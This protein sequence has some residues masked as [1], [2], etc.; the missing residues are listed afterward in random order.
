MPKW[1]G[2]RQVQCMQDDTH[3]EQLRLRISNVT[4]SLSQS[5]RPCVSCGSESSSAGI[6]IS[7]YKSGPLGRM[8]NVKSPFPFPLYLARGPSPA[9][10]HHG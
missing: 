6:S 4:T 2:V 1:V 9:H 7:V 3:P 5:R 10:D 8:L